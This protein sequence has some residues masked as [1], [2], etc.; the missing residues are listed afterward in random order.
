VTFPRRLL[1]ATGNRGKLA[2]VR[3]LLEPEG[4]VVVSPAETGWSESVE[5]DGETLDANA[6]TKARAG[7]AATGL[8]T[9][10][11][12]TGL[13]VDALGGEPGVHSARYAGPESDPVAN[14]AKLLR[15]LA[16]TPV[17]ARDAEFRCVLA[18]VT[19]TG[20]ACRWF[21]GACRGRILN[22]SRGAGGFGYDPLFQPDGSSL[23][24]AEMPGP[25]KNAV[26]HRGRAL[27]AFLDHVR[28][29]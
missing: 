5:E 3:D 15:V 2:E 22:E 29:A 20:G 26:S 18:L 27:A 16:G 12:D 23:S 25:E 14:C 1:L 19:G 17:A 13:F 10:A 28:H 6:A 4:I 24:F 11:D 8:P 7:Y 21:R 9:L